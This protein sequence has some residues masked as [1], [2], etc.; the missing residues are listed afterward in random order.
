MVE[1][2]AQGDPPK[3]EHVLIGRWRQAARRAKQVRGRVRRAPV[4]GPFGRALQGS[5]HLRIRSVGRDGQVAR[6][7]LQI[8]RQEGHRPMQLQS[9]GL[10]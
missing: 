1:H 4:P 10:R 8:V 5:G 7:F 2:P 9:P 3:G 6:P